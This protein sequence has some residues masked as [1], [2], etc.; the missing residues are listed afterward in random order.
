MSLTEPSFSDTADVGQLAC[1]CHECRD[2]YEEATAP[3][4][5]LLAMRPND[6]MLR[7]LNSVLDALGPSV[8]EGTVFPPQLESDALVYSSKLVRIRRIAAHHGIAFHQLDSHGVMIPF[9]GV[10]AFAA[11]IVY[12]E[13]RRLMQMYL[14]V[15]LVNA[16]PHLE[17]ALASFP[18]AWAL[19]AA[20][21]RIGESVMVR[22]LDRIIYGNLLVFVEVFPIFNFCIE[23]FRRFTKPIGDAIDEFETCLVD[24]RDWWGQTNYGSGDGYVARLPVDRNGTVVDG[25][26]LCLRGRNLDG[27]LGIAENEQMHTLQEF[28]YDRID[29]GIFPDPQADGTYAWFPD[30]LGDLD[31]PFYVGTNILGASLKFWYDPA[32]PNI[33][34]QFVHPFEEGNVTERNDRM[35]FTE[36][37]ITAFN[38]LFLNASDRRTIQTQHARIRSH[39]HDH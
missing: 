9:L 29:Y 10:A 6:E 3:M 24:F 18:I 2:L 35:A 33:P 39:S 21:R 8:R 12:H 20:G 30:W 16:N 31:D 28:M 5:E 37:V 23:H 11:N 4:H 25:I 15:R 36:K 38:N 7:W 32:D 22:M 13:T 19:F 26:I 27:A 34:P 14:L 1:N 17:L